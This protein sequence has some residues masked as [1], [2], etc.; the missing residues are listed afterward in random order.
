MST[1]TACHWQV[2]VNGGQQATV[3]PGESIEIGRK[4]LR[5]LPDDG[6]TRMEVED[7][8]KSMSKRHAQFSVHDDGQAVLHDLNS[9]NGTYVI[10]DAGG[11][12]RLPDDD[13]YILPYSPMHVQF[14]DVPVDFERVDAPEHEQSSQ[15]ANLFDYSTPMV[16]HQ[17]PDAADMSVDQILDLRAGEPTTMFRSQQAKP[18]RKP[19]LDGGT[20]DVSDQRTQPVSLFRP[21]PFVSPVQSEQPEQSEQSEQPGQ[22]ELSELPEQFEQSEQSEQL[23]RPAQSEQPADQPAQSLVQESAGQS[24]TQPVL[25]RYSLP[26]EPIQTTD[27]VQFGSPSQSEPLIPSAA[28]PVNSDAERPR[29]LFPDAEEPQQRPEHNLFAGI[30]ENTPNAPQAEHGESAA[31]T[32]GRSERHAAEAEGDRQESGHTDDQRSEFAQPGAGDDLDAGQDP[33][34]SESASD[35]VS[36]PE[37]AAFRETRSVV[38]AP[39]SQTASETQSS[40]GFAPVANAAD[41]VGGFTPA[42][43]PGSVFDKVSRGEFSKPPEPVIEVDGLSSEDAR[44]TPD[45]TKQ[46]EMARHAELLPFLAMNPSLYDDLYAWLA[47]QGNK[48]I[49]EALADNPGYQD[50]RKAVGK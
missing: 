41:A 9:T 28:S 12:M 13:D 24:A 23:E 16:S 10:R 21:D 17:E 15:V 25:D 42:F 8:T 3:H 45:M 19:V 11:L 27:F 49:D 26:I 22:S 46:F 47:A 39:L 48:D 6:T 36:E 7:P 18:Q 1:E 40:N 35:S 43:E 50:Y 20:D 37:T 34:Q 32:D 5:P 44:R 33:A 30:G 2:K 38:F 29:L 4:P 14:G 31:P